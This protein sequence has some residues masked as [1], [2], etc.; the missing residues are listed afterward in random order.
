MVVISVFPAEIGTIVDE[1]IIRLSDG[2]IFDLSNVAGNGFN[3]NRLAKINDAIQVEIDQLKLLTDLPIDDP[4]R[5][6]NPNRPELFW[7]DSDGNPV[8]DPFGAFL[9]AR[10][11]KIHLTFENGE[12]I[13]HCRNP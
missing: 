9:C 1:G 7:S 3:K 5:T 8:S 12:L 10:A 4:D 6:I 13:P 2:R 11:V